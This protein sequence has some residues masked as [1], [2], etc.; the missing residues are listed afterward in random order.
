MFCPSCGA[1]NNDRDQR[2]CRE[3]GTSLPVG[4]PARRAAPGSSRSQL[5]VTQPPARSGSLISGSVSNRLAVGAVATVAAV[6][7]LYVIIHV[8]L[9]V[10]ASL[11]PI[12]AVLG[13]LYLGFLYWRRT[14]RR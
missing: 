13:A 3:C 5:P 9:G 12:I 4:D 14:S 2:Y 11:I 6:V 8:V 10:I 7:V 1:P